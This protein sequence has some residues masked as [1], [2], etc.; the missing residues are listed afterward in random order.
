MRERIFST[1]SGDIHYWLSDVRA[2][3]PALVFLPG[4]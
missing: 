2:D 4:S 3:R 1:P